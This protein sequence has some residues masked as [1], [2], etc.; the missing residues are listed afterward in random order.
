LLSQQGCIRLGDIVELK[1]NLQVS[2]GGQSRVVSDWARFEDMETVRVLTRR[3]LELKG[4]VTHRVAEAADEWRRL[5]E[6]QLG[7]EFGSGRR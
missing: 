5:D 3:G 2:D 7:I 4:S 1:L 6:L